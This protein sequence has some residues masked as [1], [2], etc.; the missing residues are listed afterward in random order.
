MENLVIENNKAVAKNRC[1]MCYRCISSCPQQAITLLGDTVVEQCRYER[2]RAGLP[3][4]SEG[5]VG[6]HETTLQ[7]AKQSL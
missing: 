4:G 7:G 5:A 3:G 1:T 6:A 2:Y